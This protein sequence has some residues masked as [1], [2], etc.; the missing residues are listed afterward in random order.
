VDPL[1]EKYYSWGPYH[2]VMDNPIR[3]FDLDGTS[4][5]TDSLGNVVAVYNDD[6]LGV[7]KHNISAENYDGTKLSMADGLLMGETEYIDE[8]VEHDNNSGE[9]YFDKVTEGA[10]IIFDG[11]WGAIIDLLYADSKKY[12]LVGI[13]NRSKSHQ[14]YDIKND[15]NYA[16]FGSGTGRLLNGKYA[17]ARSAGN[18]LAGKT[19]SGGSLMGRKISLD[20]YL[21]LAGALHRGK[22]SKKNAAR[23]VL[24]GKDFG[25]EIEY[26]ERRII[27]GWKSGSNITQ[28]KTSR[29]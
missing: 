11:D 28:P 22:W 26:A 17:T 3:Y 18:Y 5:H 6:N 19:A 21:K 7:Y 9:A 27:A 24:F 1:A 16:P 29:P 2:Y 13:A 8:F 20:V 25:R 15:E 14:A 23:V 4:T 12:D 10:R